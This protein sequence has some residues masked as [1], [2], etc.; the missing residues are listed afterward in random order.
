MLRLSILS[1]LVMLLC[2]CHQ[3]TPPAEST[4][5]PVRLATVAPLQS[6]SFID[7]SGRVEGKE[8]LK[9]AFKVSGII[10]QIS[11]DTG[12][13][14]QPGQE[15]ARLDLV[16]INAQVRSAEEQAQ[17]AARDLARAEQ[18][19]HKG[20]VSTQVMQDARSQFSMAQATLDSARFNLQHARIIA[21]SAGIVLAKLAESRETVAAGTPVISLNRADSGWVLRAGLADR[22]AVQVKPGDAVEVSLD[23]FPH[24]PLQGQVARLGASSDPRTGTVEAEIALNT[25]GRPLVSGW[26]GLAR[27]HTREGQGPRPLAVPVNALLEASGER[28]HVYVVDA[29]DATAHR[30]DIRLGELRGEQVEVLEGLSAGQQVVSE[31]AAWLSDGTR[32]NVVK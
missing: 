9:L 17:K 5:Q 4:R 18:L 3:D 22:Q 31:G 28:A 12:D 7:V 2:A 21:P 20:V 30:V 16:E 13:Q 26:I 23:A 19:N 14:V 8:E 24:A 1:A 32:V 27:I 6:P 15:L 25:A 10:Q 11:V 29:R